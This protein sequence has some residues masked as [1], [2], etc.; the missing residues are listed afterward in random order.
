MSAW[1]CPHESKGICDR[2][3][4]V[5]CDPGRKG[6]VLHGR[7]RFSNDAKNRVRSGRAIGAKT[8][9]GEDALAR[10]QEPDPARGA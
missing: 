3:G 2:L 5:D 6:C 10:P 8:G 7:Y 9:S 4:G 1:G